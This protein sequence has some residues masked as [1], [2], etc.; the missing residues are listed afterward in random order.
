MR[1]HSGSEVFGEDGVVLAKEKSLCF[2]LIELLVVIAI[3]AVLASMLLPALGRAREAAKKITCQNNEKQIYLGLIG[4]ADDN[5]DYLPRPQ[6]WPH[7]IIPAYIRNRS[8]H[9]SNKTIYN[10]KIQGVLLCPSTLPYTGSY[11]GSKP[12]MTSYTSTQKTIWTAGAI[13]TKIPYGGW[14]AT[15]NGTSL[16][17]HMRTILNNT[18]IVQEAI[19]IESYAT[20][21]NV[22]TAE[23]N[24]MMPHYTNDIARNNFHY[25]VSFRH[26][27]TANFL[28]FDG[29]VTNY[30]L[31]KQ[32][33][34]DYVPQ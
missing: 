28:A 30:K 17:R 25:G 31:G 5:T 29:S 32:F 1:N 24:S 11:L 15:L 13:I 16:P 19:L 33:S 12:L 27:L 2:T 3:I 9:P 18:I 34:G 22:I 8:D 4:Y 7:Y 20:S 21:W 14:N 6:L 26:A 10:W 23:I